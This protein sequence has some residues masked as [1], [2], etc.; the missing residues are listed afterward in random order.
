MLYPLYLVNREQEGAQ[1]LAVKSVDHWHKLTPK[2]TGY[3][4]TGASSI[5]SAFG[6]GNR[7]LEKLNDYKR[8]NQPNTLYKEAG[9]VIETPLSA[10]QS[11][12]DMIIQSWGGT[13]RVFPAAP[14]AWQEIAFHDLR[15][16]GAFLVSAV[17]SAGKT[18]FVRIKS[19]AGEP[20]VIIPGLDAPVRVSAVRGSELKEIAPGRFALDL[21]KGEEAILWTGDA[22]PGLAIEAVPA[23]SGQAN[24]FGM[25]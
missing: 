22:A 1:E 24:S 18:R 19:L 16:E 13:I 12:H 4:K 14:D 2:G 11:I 25:K 9:P 8:F 5:F 17:R 15:T 20:C 21:D 10:A 23:Q 7:A 6:L 3:T